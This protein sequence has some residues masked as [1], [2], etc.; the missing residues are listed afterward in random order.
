MAGSAVV[1]ESYASVVS[2]PGWRGCFEVLGALSG[3]RTTCLAARIARGLAHRSCRDA[4]QH[5]SAGL[6]GVRNGIK[7]GAASADAAKRSGGATRCKAGS[8]AHGESYAPVGLLPGW[9]GCF[10]ALGILYRRRATR[11][12]G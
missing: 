5:E 4:C 9:S 10:D 3:R 11:W 12:L 1:G 2:L 6:L 7:A 8:A